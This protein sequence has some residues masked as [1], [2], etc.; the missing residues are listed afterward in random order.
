MAQGMAPSES[1]VAPE[2]LIE[3]RVEGSGDLRVAG[4]VKGSIAVTG[5]VTIEPGALIDGEIRA[6]RLSVAPGARMRGNVEFGWAGN[7]GEPSRDEPSEPSSFAG[8][9]RGHCPSREG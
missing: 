1:Y 8:F 3:G 6:A 2:L 4:R 5:Q 7:P 9:M